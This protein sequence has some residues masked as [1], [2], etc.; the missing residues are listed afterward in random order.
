[1]ARGRHD[2]ENVSVRP[3]VGSAG[4]GI[5]ITPPTSPPTTDFSS[6]IGQEETIKHLRTFAEL[7]TSQGKPPGNI[8]LTAPD[9]H[10]KRTLARAFAGEYGF[11]FEEFDASKDFRPVD[12]STVLSI[13]SSSNVFLVSHID[14]LPKRHIELLCC[15][16]KDFK[17]DML[18]GKGPTAR[19]Q[20][21]RLEEFTC[22]ATAYSETDCHRE[23]REAFPLKLK[24]QR[25]SELEIQRM[26]AGFAQE[27]GLTLSPSVPGL[28]AGLSHGS[29]REARA[30][31]KHIVD[32]GKT[33]ITEDDAIQ[34]LS[35]FGLTVRAR[36]STQAP[37]DLAHLSGIGFEK[38]ITQLLQQMGFV[39]EM[40]KASGD[41]GIDIVAELHKPITGGRYLIQCKNLAPDSLIG[42]PI[43]RE[44]YGAMV[45]DKKAIKGILITTSDFTR[46]AQEF[47][48][49][50]PLELI[51][52]ERLKELLANRDLKT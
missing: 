18:L 26:V 19:A 4:S 27:H 24:L 25:Y 43:V 13:L 51:N 5:L 2:K 52:G 34:I 50:L 23:L 3:H 7:Y 16:L 46:Q 33:T 49:T 11:P 39:A 42:A 44:F 1:M 31:V 20:V 32:A 47:A 22:I 21:Y 36:S 45:A 17:V 30:L 41:G 38:I 28:V 35:A 8:L 12:L 10:G 6:I 15:A 9:G 40:T 48:E 37:S 14:A 29:P